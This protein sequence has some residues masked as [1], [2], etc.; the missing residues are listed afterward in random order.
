[1][2]KTVASNVQYCMSF[3]CTD[4]AK[5]LFNELFYFVFTYYFI[6]SKIASIADYALQVLLLDPPIDSV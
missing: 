2:T 4:A 6:M 1:M 3:C 5:K